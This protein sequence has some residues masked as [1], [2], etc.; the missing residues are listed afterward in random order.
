MNDLP[1]LGAPL[2]TFQ[3]VGKTYASGTRALEAVSFTLEPGALVAVVGPSG[4][5]KTTL[6]RLAAGLEQPSEGHLARPAEPPGFTAQEA[7]LLP[8]RT[9]QRN[10]ELLLELRGVPAAERQARAQSE[11]ARVGLQDFASH[12]PAA[13]SAGMKMRVALARAL[14]VSPTLFFFDEPFAALDALTREE[15]NAALLAEFV[16]RRFAALFVT[17]SIGEAVFLASRVLVLTPRPGRIAA[18]IEVPFPYPRLP[19]IQYD[20]AF[21]KTAGAVASALR[22]ARSLKEP[23]D[24]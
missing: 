2:L 11:L 18:S 4:C 14:S 8:W 3:N 10:V 17:H 21:A 5:G 9:V 15:L 24:A 19:T 7:C 12:R 16:R 20:P 13:L 1:R 23:S 6:L 22:A